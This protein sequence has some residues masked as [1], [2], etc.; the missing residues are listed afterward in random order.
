VTPKEK[1]E[2]IRQNIPGTYEELAKKIPC[3][4]QTIHNLKAGKF[5]ANA[6]ILKGLNDLYE[7]ALEVKAVMEG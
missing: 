4:V 5:I 7:K 2:V 6:A 3:H 1:L